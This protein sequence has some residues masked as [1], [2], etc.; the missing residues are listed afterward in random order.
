M[1]PAC[2]SCGS[3]RLTTFLSL[4]E[5]PLA[6]ALVTPEGARAGEARYPLDLAFCP[7]CSLTQILE[8]VPPQTLFVDNY[9]YFSS[10]SDHLV[11]HA[12]DHAEG[13]VERRGL[14]PGS[15]VVEVASNDGYFL[16]HLLGRGIDV[17]GIDPAPD[18]A[19]A[20]REAGVPTV[21]AF[22]GS[23]LARELRDEHGPADVIVA[24]NVMAHTPALNDFVEGLAILLADDGVATIENPY[25]RELVER[26]AFDTVY[27]EHFSYFSCTAVDVLM[28]RHGLFLQHIDAF[29]DL[30]GGTLRW[31][32]GRQDG[33]DHSV[34]EHLESEREAGLLRPEYYERFGE[35]V[36]VLQD[37]LLALLRGLKAEG[38]SIA[39]YGAAAKGATL[40]NATG[41]DGELLDFVVDL[42]VHKQGLLMPGAHLPILD[43][44]ALLE[45]R[46]DYLLLLAWNFREEIARQQAAY[47]E[48]GGRFIVPVPA[49]E[50]V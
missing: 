42:N 16:R 2:R 18:Q 10:F 41:I 14:G 47:L 5:T 1:T 46:P 34:R 32:V 24:N 20:A 21:E 43:P 30:H 26:V 48:A 39:A 8:E 28:R 40:L 29:P 50:V 33:A 44:S 36:R 4:G 15:R 11:R 23:E 37:D 13:L 45:R 17:L 31:T 6:D 27:H 12:R 25:V 49:P 3:T 22:F 35:R 19:R 7:D 38:A 9:L